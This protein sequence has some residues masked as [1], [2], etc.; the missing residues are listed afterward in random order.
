MQS[1]L[2][3]DDALIAQ[4]LGSRY[5]GRRYLRYAELEAL[6]LVDNRAS[7]KLWMDADAFPRGIRIPGRHGKTLV[8][9]AA[10]VARL[11]AQRTAERDAS[12]NEEGAPATERPSD[13]DDPPRAETTSTMHGTRRQRPDAS[14]R[15]GLGRARRRYP[16]PRQ[17]RRC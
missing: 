14:G 12:P 2:D 13:S 16:C 4:F 1:Q 11:I 5:L 8:W 7:L 17:A 15:S 6:G 3:L 9:S 10:E